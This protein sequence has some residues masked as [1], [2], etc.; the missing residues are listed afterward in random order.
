[1][2]PP[3]LPALR[4]LRAAWEYRDPPAPWES[5]ALWVLQGR[6][7]PRDCPALQAPRALR[8]QLVQQDLPDLQGLRAVW[9]YRAPQGRQD[10][11]VPQGPLALLAPRVLL[12]R[13]A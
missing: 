6:K 3:V 2:A 9:E 12:V 4:G 8:E 13:L 5:P 1:M 7:V 11:L 10:P